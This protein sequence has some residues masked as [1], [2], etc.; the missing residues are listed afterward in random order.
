MK[1]L[2]T[3][4]L[5][6]SACSQNREARQHR[7]PKDL[8]RTLYLSKCVSCHQINGRGIK[9]EQQ[10]AADF[11]DPEGPLKKS[12]RALLLAISEGYSGTLGQ[13]PAFK[14]ILS[15]EEQKSVLAYIRKTFGAPKD[16][17]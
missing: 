7:K 8:G 3:L 13:M 10:Y 17:P 1:K 12:D 14:P 4:F 15:F 6:L 2:L 16:T 11:T 5:I 9:F